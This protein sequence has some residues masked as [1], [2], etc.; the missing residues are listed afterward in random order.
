[1]RSALKHV[2]VTVWQRCCKVMV[3]LPGS[4]LQRYL[5]MWFPVRPKFAKSGKASDHGHVISE[6][7]AE[8]QN[9]DEVV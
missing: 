2:Q 9:M 1:M 5:F 7:A 8:K 6:T 4:T 3:V